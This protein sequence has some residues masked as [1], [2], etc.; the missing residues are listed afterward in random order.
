[1][2][3]SIREIPRKKH[4]IGRFFAFLGVTL[5]CVVL[6]LVGVVWVL[7]RGP[8]PTVTGMF[9]RSVRETSALRWMSRMFL[10]EDE[11]ESYKSVS[12]DDLETVSVNTS[13]RATM[14]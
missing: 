5:L 13:L 2:N 4:P 11:L 10:S 6:V 8:S 3:D 7:E 1:M 14:P 12:T 9:C